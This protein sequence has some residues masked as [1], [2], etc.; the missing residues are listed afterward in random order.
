MQ[1]GLFFLS[2]FSS[3]HVAGAL[4]GRIALKVPHPLAFG[5]DGPR[6]RDL[7][8]YRGEVV[9]AGA[10][11][12]QPLPIL[13]GEVGAQRRVRNIVRKVQ[14]P[15]VGKK[16]IRFP[17]DTG[18]PRMNSVACDR[19]RPAGTVSDQL[20]TVPCAS[21]GGAGRYFALDHG[22]DFVFGALQIEARL[23]VDP[24]LGTGAEVAAQ[25]QRS[26]GA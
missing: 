24:K 10:Q 13:S 21:G 11:V 19:S 4:R 2:I 22:A 25:T 6:L 1:P 16:L 12:E 18:L 9:G 8:R 7:S 15:A 23:H 14:R 20:N 3:T 26:V 5:P 17:R